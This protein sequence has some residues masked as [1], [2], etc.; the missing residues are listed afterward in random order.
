M[1]LILTDNNSGYVFGDYITSDRLCNDV[2]ADAARHVDA[3]I[4]MH[5]RAYEVLGHDPRDTSTGY[6]VW[7]SDINGSDMVPNITD[8]QDAELLAAL[9]RDC[10]YLG[11]VI[12]KD[13]G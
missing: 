12:C 8:G 4:G 10:E 5:D 13:A 6:H 1:R 2:M 11:Y 3:E 7:R 9:E